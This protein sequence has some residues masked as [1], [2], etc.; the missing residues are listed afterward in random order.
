VLLIPDP[1]RSSMIVLAPS[2]VVAQIETWLEHL[3]QPTPRT[4]DTEIVEVK[5]GD[6]EEVAK[7]LNTMLASYPDQ[8][9]RNALQ[10]IPFGTSQ[11]LMIV[12][13]ETNRKMVTDWLEQIDEA[14]QPLE[15]RTFELENADA[16]E[17]ADMITELFEENT[18]RGGRYYPV[19]IYGG[20]RGGGAKTDRSKVT[21]SADTRRNSIT[22]VASP[23]KMEGIVEQVAKWDSPLA[24]DLTK[25]RVFDL[26]YIDPE[27][28]KTLLENLFSKKEDDGFSNLFF[29]GRDDSA[30]VSPVG[31][32]HG[33]FMFEAV[34]DM[35]RLIVVSKT[36][37]NFQYIEELIDDLD[38][39]QAMGLPRV[40]QLKFADA[41][42]LAE[43]LNAL[44]N[45]PGTP[46]S[47]LRQGRR[48]EFSRRSDDTSPFSTD[49]RRQQGQPGPQGPNQQGQ[50]NAGTMPFW[51]AN[52][53][54]D[55]KS[56]QPSS[57]VGKVRI[58]PHVEQNLLLVAASEEDG[59]AIEEL[60]AKLDR[61][62]L[63][64]LVKAVIAEI[65]HDDSMS[66]GYRFSTDPSAFITGDPLLT[67]IKWK[68]HK[69]NRRVVPPGETWILTYETTAALPKGFYA[70]EVDIKFDKGLTL[71]PVAGPEAG[72]G[73][74][75]YTYK[76][77]IENE[78]NEALEVNEV[79]VKLPKVLAYDSVTG[80]IF[81]PV[82][83]DPSDLSPGQPTNQSDKEIKWNYGDGDVSLD[84]GAKWEW[85]LKIRADL[86]AV[87]GP[88]QID[89]KTTEN[90]KEEK[91]ADRVTGPTAII[92]VTEAYRVTI[93]VGGKTFECDIWFVLD[94]DEEIVQ[95]QMLEGCVF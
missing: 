15:M 18:G 50:Q 75:F 58:V 31:R 11:R 40:I 74:D 86:G 80:V 38:R 9:L 69:D 88:I 72:P 42:T 85:T 73:F 44:L 43:Q 37:D 95:Y 62:V 77:P 55:T 71:V 76:I 2:N 49:G 57:L 90:D 14:G 47:I 65:T 12:G 28:L 3:D 78:G 41:E 87:A 29:F 4:T 51:W 66:L 10:I 36:E 26:K 22:V 79:K 64:V 25:P 46:A 82:T 20:S 19:F 54:E 34:P 23:E 53:R 52:L 70:A 13:S 63:Q 35:G 91:V 7:Q 17:V 93:T 8:G 60:V 30:S 89:F 61:P 81:D 83:N 21:V 84:P 56:K 68:F 39:P 6:P 1:R 16:Q 92:T 45:A 59:E 32:L 27:E 33:Q 5:Y 94:E 48:G 67:E 24:G